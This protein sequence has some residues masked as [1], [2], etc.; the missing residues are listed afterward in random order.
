MKTTC[1]I[2]THDGER[3]GNGKVNDPYIRNS[4]SYGL[5]DPY[6]PAF[7]DIASARSWC[8]RVGAVPLESTIDEATRIAR[9]NGAELQLT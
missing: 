3:D 4:D 6:F 8:K 7:T 5:I 9:S 1:Y 2:P